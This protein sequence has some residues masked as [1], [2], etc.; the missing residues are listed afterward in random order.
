M[1][2]IQTLAIFGLAALLLFAATGFL[3]PAFS[4]ASDL[5]PIL[6]WFWVGG[7]GLFAPLGMA[8]YILL[9]QASVFSEPAQQH[10]F[11]GGNNTH[12]RS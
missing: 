3:I 8:G 2:W 4:E 12:Q 9:H 6:W 11:I 1:G 10:R 5:E 7:L